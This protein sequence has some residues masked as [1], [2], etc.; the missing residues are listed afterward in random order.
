MPI[1]MSVCCKQCMLPFSLYVQLLEELR[2]AAH[3][4]KVRNAPSRLSL[5]V[6]AD[7]SLSLCCLLCQCTN[8]VLTS[9]CTFDRS[10]F[11]Y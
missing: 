4:Q 5:V 10:A 8:R 1:H 9:V 11:M 6:G 7:L 3:Q 2:V